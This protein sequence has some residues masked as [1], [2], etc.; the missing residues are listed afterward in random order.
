MLLIPF[1]DPAGGWFDHVFVKLFLPLVDRRGHSVKYLT[2]RHAPPRLYFVRAALAG[3]LSPVSPLWV[4]EGVKQTL[5]ATQLGLAAVG[6]C[7]IHA[8][9][10]RGSTAL[11]PDFDLIPLHGRRVEL[12]SD[13]DVRTNP[14]VEAG[15]SQLAEALERRGARV[16]IVL[17]PVAA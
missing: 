14:A 7:G 16:R 2:R 9:H 1:P 11:L 4:I 5:A 8:W 12:V 17:L 6:F 3:V 10:R 13:G 15:A